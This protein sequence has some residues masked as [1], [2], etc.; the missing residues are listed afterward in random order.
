MKHER[1]KPTRAGA[2]A[3]QRLVHLGRE[4]QEVRESAGLTQGQLAR[5]IG[6][7]TATVS[8]IEAAKQRLDMPT[9][10]AMTDEL[11]IA[12]DHLILRAEL[13]RKPMTPLRREI[14]G[15]FKKMLEPAKRRKR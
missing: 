9:F 7:S 8:K 10:L 15:V 3:D 5:R 14:L 2:S 6:K 1:V 12:A 11:G 13:A 4:L